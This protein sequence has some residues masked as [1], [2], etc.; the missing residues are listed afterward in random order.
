MKIQIVILLFLSKLIFSQTPDEINRVFISNNFSLSEVGLSY[1]IKIGVKELK[2]YTIKKE[3]T[4]LVY[5]KTFYKDGKIK[6]S[7]N[8]EQNRMIFTTY[9]NFSKILKDKIYHFE[10]EKFLNIKDSISMYY[11]YNTSNK[12]D[13]IL[14]INEVT[15]DTNYYLYSYD[16]DVR[17]INKFKNKD[18][19][20]RYSY[21]NFKKSLCRL[22]EP[23]NQFLV[24]THLKKLVHFSSH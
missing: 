2:Q 12:V 4:I 24:K 20:F 3:D 13:T 9:N 17:L 11:K 8:F 5:H 10:D 7:N 22:K 21:N 23:V 16:D 19:L 6:K 1:E 14:R 18:T 15:N